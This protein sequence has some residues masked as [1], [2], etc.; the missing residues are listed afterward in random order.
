MGGKRRILYQFYRLDDDK[1]PSTNNA[2]QMGE[3]W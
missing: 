1:I 2:M 3:M